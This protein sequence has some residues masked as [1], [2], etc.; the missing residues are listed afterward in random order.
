MTNSRLKDYLDLVVLLEQED[1]DPNTLSNAIAATFDANLGLQFGMWQLPQSFE[2]RLRW[3]GHD[4]STH[5]QNVDVLCLASTFV[6]GIFFLR[7]NCTA[8]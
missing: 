2:C 1:L 6:A 3:P 8:C 5:W 4:I 7:Q